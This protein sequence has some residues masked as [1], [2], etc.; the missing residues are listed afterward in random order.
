MDKEHE[1]N[2]YFYSTFEFIPFCVVVINN[3][4]TVFLN[5]LAV[6]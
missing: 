1:I 4:S 3:L 6:K 5:K 2:Y